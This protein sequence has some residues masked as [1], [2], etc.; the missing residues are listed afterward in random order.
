[1]K[2]FFNQNLIV[3][4]LSLPLSFLFA[5]TPEK[6]SNNQFQFLEG[7]VWDGT[8]IIY[9]SDIPSSKVVSY[10][11][12]TKTFSDVFTNTNRPNGL[13]F[14]ENFN[15]LVCE[16]GSGRITRRQI[17]GTILDTLA[18]TFNGSR[19][20]GPNDLCIDKKGGI[21][22]TDPD[23][24]S[25]SQPQN[26]LY[27]R[28]NAG[29]INAQDNFRDGKPN[30]VIISPN[31]LFLYVN[32]TSSKYIFRYN[33]DSENGALSSRIIY[34]ELPD[35]SE[36]TGA[37]GMAV[38]TDGKLYVTAKRTIQ[39]FDGSQR[40]PINTILFP[41]NTTNCTFGG[42]NKNILFVTAGQNLYQVTDI[43][44]IG[45]Q[46]PFDL[47]E[48]IVTPPPT[49]ANID[50]EAEA[51]DRTGGAF[52]GVNRY[53]T[54]N[55]TRGTNFN[56][57]GDWVE[58]SISIPENGNFDVTY[59]IS[60]PIN[61]TAIELFIDNVSVSKDNVI[62]NR[63]WDNFIPLN[64][65]N[66]VF[67]TKGQ[68]TIKLL[69]A[70]T[71]PNKWEW[72][73]DRFRLSSTNSTNRSTNSLSDIN[74]ILIS[75]NPVKSFFMIKGLEENVLSNYSIIDINGRSVASGILKNTNHQVNNLESLRPGMYFIETYTTEG[76][77]YINKIS[78]E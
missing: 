37:D 50:I 13:M 57:T 3:I 67:L 32:N 23:F 31:G 58:Y 27:Y 19:F 20:N 7:P 55:G 16:G 75:P 64:A 38:D 44:A 18:D 29:I 15:L 40:A 76:V 17:N 4:I 26:R 39:V 65:S 41:E 43:N 33:I 51:F 54:T 53:T 9:F 28:N 68:H 46:H 34:G 5:Q 63:N 47:P 69:G 77:R 25:S 1:M 62:N 45:V 78:K 6:L 30:G 48:I 8:D 24:E 35:N 70:G 49:T 36:N 11:L 60:T 2:T 72:N 10:R 74:S 56:Q 66:K 61:N 12:S 42:V 52:Q 21:Y 71:N 22:F 14:N 73:L 59:Y